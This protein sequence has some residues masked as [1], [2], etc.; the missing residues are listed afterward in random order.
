VAGVLSP[1]DAYLRAAAGQPFVWGERDC[2]LWAA[3]WIKARTGRD[4]AEGFRGRYRTRLG[5]HRLVRR[6]GG[7]QPAMRELA[8]R[9]GLAE[10]ECGE[11]AAPGD[12]ALVVMQPHPVLAIRGRIGWACK[13]ERGVVESALFRDIRVWAVA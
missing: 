4:P 7:W 8:E 1:L 6:L 5:A 13:T 11:D 3:D 12:V 2:C 9:A 10:R